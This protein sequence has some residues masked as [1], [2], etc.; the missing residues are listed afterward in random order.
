MQLKGKNWEVMVGDCLHNLKLIAPK[1][2]DLVFADPPFN[3]GYKYDKYVDKLSEKDYLRWVN[4]WLIRCKVVLKSTGS[5]WVAIGPKYQA[6]IKCLL[7][8]HYHW[9]NTIIWHYT[10]GPRQVSN[11]T[12]SWTAI[13]Y[14]TVGSC[15]T[16]NPDQVLV[17]S[18]RQLKYKDKRAVSM[19]KVPD[20]VWNLLPNDN[21]L[22]FGIGDNAW[23]ESRVC[24]TY[25]ERTKHPCQM[26]LP[27]LER[28]IK[29]CSREGDTVLDPFAGSGTSLEAALR[30]KRRALGIELSRHYVNDIIV[31]R[32]NKL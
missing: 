15:Y 7:D 9:R 24:G 26:P 8:K 11:Y 30:L 6:Q 4:Q 10:F 12:P 16:W 31:P 18:A 21:A 23:L 20:N 3:I 28:I 25:K 13:H 27:I 32:I 5:I 17:P 19:G 29:S 1:S 2:V 22:A 14:Y